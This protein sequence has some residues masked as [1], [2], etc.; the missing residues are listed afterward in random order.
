MHFS[1]PFIILLS[2]LMFVASKEIG[3]VQINCQHNINPIGEFPMC[4]GDYI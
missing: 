1:I 4:L 2:F 3:R